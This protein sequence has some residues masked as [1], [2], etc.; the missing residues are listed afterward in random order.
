VA[1]VWGPTAGYFAKQSNVPLQVTPI[2]QQKDGEI[3]LA[4]DISVGIKRSNK[5]LKQEIDSVLA[6][7][8][9]EINQILDE[10]GVPRVEKPQA[11]S[12]GK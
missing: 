4:F 12:A 8:Q 6:T 2:T 11:A 5:A 9:D 3:P 10:Y 1:F 7:R